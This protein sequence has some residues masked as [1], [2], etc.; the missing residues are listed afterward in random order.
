MP[1]LPDDFDRLVMRCLAKRPEDRFQT[2]EELTLALD[3][4]TVAGSWTRSEASNW[5]Q[6]RSLP[7]SDAPLAAAVG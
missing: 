3:E 7:A 1:T 5:W 4:C 6:Q 2:V